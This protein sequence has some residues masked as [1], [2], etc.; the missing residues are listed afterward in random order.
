MSLDFLSELSIVCA[1]MGGRLPDELSSTELCDLIQIQCITLGQ[2]IAARGAA[3]SVVD[4]L[5][6]VV[7]SNAA[8]L[9]KR[10]NQLEKK[11]NN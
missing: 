10:I 2:T 1:G 3:S 9:E 5:E 6:A 4:F 7:R 8:I 11:G